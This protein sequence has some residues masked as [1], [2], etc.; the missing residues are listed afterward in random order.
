MLLMMRSHGW[1]RDLPPEKQKELRD[2]YSCSDFDALYNFYVPGFNLRATDLQAYIGLKAI[3]KLDK[4]CM[5]RNKNFVTYLDRLK[6]NLLN[7]ENKKDNF[8][9]NFAMPFVN[10]NR[11]KIINEL[12][13][14]NIEVRPLIAGNMA[15]KPM[16]VNFN[17]VKLSLPNCELIEKFGFYIPNHQNLTYQ[18]ITF[19]SN[20]INKH[21]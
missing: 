5:A 6:G 3:D 7:I 19:I 16:W 17:P 20:I 13:A 15:S 9:S 21:A 10:K 11:N 12:I 1:D 14:N 8:I 4:F 18:D 2:Q